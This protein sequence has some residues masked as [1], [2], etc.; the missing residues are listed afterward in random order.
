MK[1]LSSGILHTAISVHDSNNSKS[2]REYSNRE[3]RKGAAQSIGTTSDPEV[4]LNEQ[5][6]PGG[7]QQG[8]HISEEILTQINEVNICIDHKIELEVAYLPGFRRH[9]EFE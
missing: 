1:E 7:Q 4:G 8:F 3:C 9:L 2:M 6:E 5:G